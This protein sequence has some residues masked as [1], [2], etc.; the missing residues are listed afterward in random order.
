MK[1]IK[2][3]D[4]VRVIDNGKVYTTHSDWFSQLGFKNKQINDDPKEGTKAKVFGKVLGHDVFGCRYEDKEF[5]I[6]VNGIELLEDMKELKLEVGKTYLDRENRK[7]KIIKN[8]GDVHYPFDGDNGHCY[9]SHGR[10]FLLV[11][12]S[13]H[14]LI[15][16]YTEHTEFVLPKKWF[17]RPIDEESDKILVR[18]R[19][20]GHG[21]HW[22][23][24]ILISDNIWVS[25]LYCALGQYTEITFEQFKQHVLKQKTE[26]TMGKKIIGYN[27]RPEFENLKYDIA[28]TLGCHTGNIPNGCWL[29]QLGI[30]GVTEKAKKLGVLDL[31]FEPVYSQPYKVGDFV[32]PIKLG[33]N[34]T[35]NIKYKKEYII[36]EVIKIDSI[37]KGSRTNH[38]V[39]LSKNGHVLHIEQFE[40]KFRLATPEEIEEALNPKEEIINIG[41]DVRIKDGKA[42][43]KNDNIT[44]FVKEMIDR[45]T[46]DGILDAYG[47]GIGDVEFSF[48]G[49]EKK[50]TKLSDWKKIYDKIK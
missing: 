46:P 6:G 15:Y 3:G 33:G 36:G 41:F 30:N 49:C 16:E 2:I 24:S 44:E 1:E 47:F 31:W 38:N 18:Y 10:I 40:D 37:E 26:T 21:G 7:V 34:D 9:T 39:A 23:R 27:L 8:D 5:L 50:T 43:H 32:V 28:K 14:D 17:V 12:E 22:S 11:T 20:G 35:S 45:F 13:D 48:T 29:P 42:F 19:D 4:E 25:N